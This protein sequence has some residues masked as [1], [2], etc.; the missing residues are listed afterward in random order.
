MKYKTSLK[1]SLK[2]YPTIFPLG[3][4]SVLE[5]MF[6]VNGN[7]LRWKN[8]E[9]T[10]GYTIKQMYENNE[11]YKR[12]LK[13]QLEDQLVRCAGVPELEKLFT[14]WLNN[15]YFGAPPD[16]PDFNKKYELYPLW[17]KS[18]IMLI[19]DNIKDDWL[20]AAEKALDMVR[21]KIYIPSESDKK[22]L[23]KARRRV[24]ELKKMGGIK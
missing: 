4:Y 3:E 23:R 7:G 17:E 21:D 22:F 8:G 24:N 20:L 19:P 16:P 13:L 1:L 11:A 18:T 5:H 2:F 6:F 10:D 12:Q 9:L 14:E 15:G